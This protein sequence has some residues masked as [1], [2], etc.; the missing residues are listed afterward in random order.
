[1]DTPDTTA[2]QIKALLVY[3]FTAL[4]LFGVT[5]ASGTQ[6]LITYVVVGLVTIVFPSVL[7]IADAVIRSAR[8]KNI[9]AILRS[10]D[11]AVAPPQPSYVE[12]EGP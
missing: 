7:L 8:A 2:A 6:D 1:V 4:P 10:R 5:V 12:G 11:P 9:D 3:I